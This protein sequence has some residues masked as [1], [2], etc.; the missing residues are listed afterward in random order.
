MNPEEGELRP[1][2][3]DRFG[4]TVE[5]AA[6]RDPA[7][8]AEVVRRRL[9]FEA[10]PGGFTA[11]YAAD[12][13]ALTDRIRAAQKLVD[14]VELSDAALTRIAVVCAAF[15]VDG[16]RAD[17]VTARAAV[18]H[19]AWHG[20]SVVLR[21][22]IRAAARLALPHRRRRNPFD[23]PG[24]DE[25]LL[26]R[27]LGDD[28]PPPPPEGPDG[29]G[30]TTSYGGEPSG[31][32]GRDAEGSSETGRA[33][34]GDAGPD[35]DPSEQAPATPGGA[36]PGS[37]VGAA[38][39]Y[40]PRLFTV[41]GTGTGDAGRRSRAITSNGRRVGAERPGRSGGP[42]HPT[43]PGPVPGSPSGPRTSGSRSG[44][45]GSPTWCC[46]ASTRRGRWPPGSAWSR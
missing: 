4:L 19:A 12:E 21:E 13:A 32:G 42:I 34:P 30:D 18:A 45:G 35:T 44:R 43:G 11:R 26:D 5:V 31:D 46:S 41:A 1:Q 8:R 17:I 2:L 29:G 9:A 20:R 25:E 39:P 22:D 33:Q 10:D 36:S 3:L 14:Q 37:T 7:L 24:L 38:T 16:M 27:L 15:D 23:A 6:P 28:D 40:R